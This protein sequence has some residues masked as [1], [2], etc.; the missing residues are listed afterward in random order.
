MASSQN[1]SSATGD[2]VI[3]VLRKE[4]DSLR[5]EWEATFLPETWKNALD[6]AK[7]AMNSENKQFQITEVVCLG[8]G[9]LTASDEIYREVSLRQLAILL[10][11]VKFLPEQGGA[12]K[13]LRI[14]FQDPA[15]SKLDKELLESLGYE[16]VFG[17]R[18][19]YLV[20]DTSLL[21]TP[22]CDWDAVFPLFAHVRPALWI[23]NDWF[24]QQSFHRAQ[25]V[26]ESAKL[27]TVLEPAFRN[28][29]ESRASCK[30]LV[31]RRNCNH[32]KNWG[33]GSHFKVYWRAT[34]ED[35]KDKDKSIPRYYKCLENKT[36]TPVTRDD[37][38]SCGGP[39]YNPE[40]R[41]MTM[42]SKGS[43][44]SSKAFLNRV[45]PSDEVI[46]E[47]RSGKYPLHMQQ[48]IEQWLASARKPFP[49]PEHS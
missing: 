25:L 3:G 15:F 17:N 9:H 32:G 6:K 37:F 43:D 42:E 8:I 36:L 30:L 16:V 48:E 40:Q 44:E 19:S 11:V 38:R 24:S 34:G 31:E 20:T 35:D 45:L 27:E 13:N 21:Y 4:I 5:K 22:N 7:F 1:P 10:E 29:A 46:G 47:R 49:T 14:Y 28:F 39:E 23:S 33:W 26:R 18:S 2:T 41:S 12:S